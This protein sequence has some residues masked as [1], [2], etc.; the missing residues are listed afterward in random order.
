[1]SKHST[2]QEGQLLLYKG[3][4]FEQFDKQQ[5]YMD[6]LGYDSNGWTDLWVNYNGN[7]MRVDRADVEPIEK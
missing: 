7:K 3:Q 2:L 4:E 1:M 6:F 5:P